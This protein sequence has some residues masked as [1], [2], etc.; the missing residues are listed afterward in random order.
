MLLQTADCSDK[1]GL[2]TRRIKASQ[3]L[4]IVCAF[5]YS[6][7]T[8]S[9]PLQMWPPANALIFTRP[10][11]NNRFQLAAE[12]VLAWSNNGKANGSLE[13]LLVVH[14]A[15]QSDQQHQNTVDQAI[16][17]ACSATGHG[18][19]WES[20]DLICIGL[21]LIGQWQAR[22]VERLPVINPRPEG[23][24]SRLVINPRHEGLR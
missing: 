10:C 2:V 1:R 4:P 3:M 14:K 11:L 6:R 15:T 7:K 5:S 12:V 19:L 8:S 17:H 18:S 9:L 24:G 21:L 20:F 13:A 22:V 16:E 23:Y